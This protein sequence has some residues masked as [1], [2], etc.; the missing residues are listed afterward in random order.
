MFVKIKILDSV[1]KLLK[2]KNISIEQLAKELKMARPAL[3]NSLNNKSSIKIETLIKIAEFLNVELSVLLG[4]DTPNKVINSLGDI[5]KYSED[6]QRNYANFVN[7]LPQN[8]D[9]E[10]IK[11]RF[12]FWSDAQQEKYK[13]Y[14]NRLWAVDNNIGSINAKVLDMIN[15]LKKVDNLNN[16]ATNDNS[17]EKIE[18]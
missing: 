17:T 4:N 18:K 3:N 8:N 13:D 14:L 5:L 9:I 7:G 16:S 10:D 2:N 11:G 1:K 12:K 6:L 15:Q